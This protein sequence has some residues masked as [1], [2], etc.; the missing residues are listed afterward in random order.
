MRLV[1]VLVSVT[2]LREVDEI[3]LNGLASYETRQEF[4]NDAIQNQVLEVKH[5]E[6]AADRAEA[7]T[8]APAAKPA[9][10]G[11][12]GGG[13][14]PSSHVAPKS[15]GHEPALAQPKHA[16]AED[17][18][19]QIDSIAQT[20]IVLPADAPFL[21]DDRGEAVA[22]EE[23]LFGL[24]N[25]DYP[26]MRAAALL[27]TLTRETP[28]AIADFFEAA[29]RDAWDLALSLQRLERATKLKLTALLPSNPAKPQSAEDNYRTFAIGWIPRRVAPGEPLT[30]A[31]PL[32]SWGVCGIKSGGTREIALTT[33]GWALLKHLDGLTLAWP[34]EERYAERFCDFLRAQAPWDWECFALLL[35]QAS[36]GAGRAE[37]VD[38]FHQRHPAWTSVV[39]STNAAGYVAR[40]REWGLIEPS[41]RARR[42]VLTELGRRQCV[43]EE[44][45]R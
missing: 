7:P 14:A 28:V 32:F 29:T 22:K 17:L 4:I 20:R 40:A 21:Y 27:A 31:G 43:R 19:E 15:A 30:V 12:L 1:R 36:E 42:Y 10:N 41:L 37:L 23:P 34:H 2:L 38:A 26:S 44:S 8:R 9:A 45:S 18:T 6:A 11:S 5:G 33:S 25:R 13:R 39:A 24:H 16:N 35:Q 3:V